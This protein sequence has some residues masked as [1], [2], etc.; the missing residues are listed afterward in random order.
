MATVHRLYIM[1]A[2]LTSAIAVI[3]ALVALATE[4]WVESEYNYSELG[5]DDIIHGNINYG[6]FSGMETSYLTSS[7]WAIYITCLYGHN[8]CGW[9]CDSDGDRRADILEQY[10]ENETYTNTDRINC[11]SIS[12]A[13]PVTFHTHSLKG[14]EYDERSFINAGAYLCTVLFLI[15]AVVSGAV[16]AGLSA[17]NS[18]MNPIYWWLSI[19]ALYICNLVAFLCT[20]LYMSLW[21]G[22]YAVTIH[23]DVV[24][25]ETL[26]RVAKTNGLADLGYSYWINFVPLVFYPVSIGLLYTRSIIISRDPIHQIEKSMDTPEN[27][28][29]YLF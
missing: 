12:K 3:L 22:M 28:D 24:T 17:W 10:Y 13:F 29:I 6:L 8:I 11:N 21:G 2:S 9:L 14:N 19:P 26:N 5:S 25:M 20:V 7:R 27:P 16:A 1:L 23:K 15:F 18:V 4:Y